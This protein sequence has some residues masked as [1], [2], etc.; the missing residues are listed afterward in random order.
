MGI[1]TAEI[2]NPTATNHQDSPA[3]N[4]SQGGSIKLPAPKNKEKS[5][6]AVMKTDFLGFI[7]SEIFVKIV[8][9]CILAGPV[10]DR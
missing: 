7:G 2:Q 3:L 4:P 8:Q 9:N 1:K 6:N 5:A 10:V